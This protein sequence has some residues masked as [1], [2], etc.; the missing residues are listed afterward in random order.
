MMK[1]PV[2]TGQ[3]CITGVGWKSLPGI[4][5]Q[6]SPTGPTDDVG[7]VLAER[8]PW[9]ISCLDQGARPSKVHSPIGSLIHKQASDVR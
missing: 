4:N 6:I 3:I 1:N 8:H 7:K 5:Q 2:C 9:I